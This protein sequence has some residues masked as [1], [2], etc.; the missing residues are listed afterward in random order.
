MALN[1]LVIIANAFQ[2]QILAQLSIFMSLSQQLI[3]IAHIIHGHGVLVKQMPIIM[4]VFITVDL[5]MM[6]FVIFA[7][8]IAKHVMDLIKL[9]ALLVKD[10]I[11]CGLKDQ[12]IANKVV[13]WEYIHG[14]LEIG[15]DSILTRL[16]LT[17]RLVLVIEH[18]VI[19]LISVDG[20]EIVLQIVY[21]VVMVIS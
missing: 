20:V 1:S 10:L 7:I 11:I 6:V 13:Q 19:V 12:I 3:M 16:M 17:L 5:I 21:N 4:I 8:S 15:M 9:I 18:A 14:V 2:L